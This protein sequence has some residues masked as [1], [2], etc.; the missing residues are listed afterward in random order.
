MKVN[1]DGQAI[2]AVISLQNLLHMR[3]LTLDA[4][5][6]ENFVKLRICDEKRDYAILWFVW[7]NM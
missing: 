3:H 4:K 2:E 1:K 7:L 6:T 5:A